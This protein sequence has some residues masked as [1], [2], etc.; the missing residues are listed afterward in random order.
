MLSAVS[1]VRASTEAAAAPSAGWVAPVIFAS[2][3]APVTGYAVNR[4][5]TGLLS[6]G[7]LS[8]AAVIR[9]PA[10]KAATSNLTYE[11]RVSPPA[12]P[13]TSLSAEPKLAVVR[14][15][16]TYASSLA[17]IARVCA[18]VAA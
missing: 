18:V 5:A 6:N 9:A 1:V 15:L 17:A 16:D 3:Q 10:G 11:V 13:T 12:V 14:L 4:A 8:V 7:R 2:V